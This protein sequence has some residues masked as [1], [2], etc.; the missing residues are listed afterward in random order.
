MDQFL[1]EARI[2]IILFGY[3]I[4]PIINVMQICFPNLQIILH[5]MN[6]DSLLELLSY[7]YLLLQKF[8][9]NFK[10]ILKSFK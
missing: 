10:L 3:N 1:I 7:F 9:T 4:I 5:F 8:T 6:T 2:P